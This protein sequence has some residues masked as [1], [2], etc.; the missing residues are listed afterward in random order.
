MDSK[1]SSPAAAHSAHRFTP[2]VMTGTPSEPA[3]VLGP[4]SMTSSSSLGD[5][6]GGREWGRQ[7]V[8]VHGSSV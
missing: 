6:E 2:I 8:W 5:R 3:T 1:R 4:S 7:Q